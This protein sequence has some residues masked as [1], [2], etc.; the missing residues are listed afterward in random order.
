MRKLRQKVADSSAAP[1]MF[2]VYVMGFH[3]IA[4][5][6]SRFPQNLWKI[7]NFARLKTCLWILRGYTHRI[8]FEKKNSLSMHCNVLD[9]AEI[10]DFEKLVTEDFLHSHEFGE[11]L[12]RRNTTEFQ[13]FC[14]RRR[15]FAHYFIDV[16]VSHHVTSAECLQSIYCFCP[17]QLLEGNDHHVF[18]LRLVRVLEMSGPSGRRN[19]RLPQKTLSLSLLTFALLMLAVVVV[20]RKLAILLVISWLI[21]V[22]C[23]KECLLRV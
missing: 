3:R 16:I 11:A 15:E 13:E 23:S 14:N 2:Y 18:D 7:I 17:E 12:R 22:S 10:L 4:L 1:L 9:P 20:Q 6:V 21:T 5:T 8:F 19:Q